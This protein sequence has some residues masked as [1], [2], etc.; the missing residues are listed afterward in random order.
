MANTYTQ[1]LIQLVF[2]V[3]NRANLITEELRADV[4]KY[5][6]GIIRNNGHRPLA[7]F[8]MPDHTH[9]LFGLNPNQSLSSLVRDVK[10]NSSRWINQCGRLKFK[11]QWQE[12]YGA[13]SYSKNQINAVARYILNQPDHHKNKRIQGRIYPTFDSIRY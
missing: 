12:G 8:C 10:C 11:F 3:K 6:T 1:L 5:I 2:T 9:I 13:F 7:I 4:Q